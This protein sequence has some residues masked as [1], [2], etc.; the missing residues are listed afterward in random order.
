MWRRADRG[1]RGGKVE[2]VLDLESRQKK[3]KEG[4]GSE[5]IVIEKEITH[6]HY[7]EALFGGKQ[8]LHK[9]KI[10]RSKVLYEQDLN[11]PVRHKALDSRCW[12][13]H[14]GI[15]AQS[16]QAGRSCVLGGTTNSS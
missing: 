14:A 16:N 4:E 10:L 7:K 11:I 6:E 12:R 3:Y 13:P 1:S 9:M 2:D 5:K 8:F 15:R